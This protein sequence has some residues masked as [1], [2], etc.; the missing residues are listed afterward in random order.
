ML[1]T[2][3]NWTRSLSPYDSAGKRTAVSIRGPSTTH[4]QMRHTECSY[5]KPRRYSI[6]VGK[7]II[8]IYL[9]NPG[10]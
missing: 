7:A 3:L 2:P 1:Q 6:R 8:L 9:T 5:I 4:P 10:G